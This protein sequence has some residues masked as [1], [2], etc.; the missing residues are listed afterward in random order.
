MRDILNKKI[1]TDLLSSILSFLPSF[2]IVIILTIKSELNNN[3]SN[4]N[5]YNY[6]LGSNNNSV[7]Q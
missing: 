1:I 2:V 3:K 7:T 6:K 4:K 5:I